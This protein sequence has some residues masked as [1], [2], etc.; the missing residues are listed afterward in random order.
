MIGHLADC[1]SCC[2][3]HHRVRIDWWSEENATFD[4]VLRDDADSADSAGASIMEHGV[5]HRLLDELNAGFLLHVLLVVFADETIDE[6]TAGASDCAT[7]TN[8]HAA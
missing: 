5:E 2:W 8:H 6:R 3:S 7:L 4:A 1:K